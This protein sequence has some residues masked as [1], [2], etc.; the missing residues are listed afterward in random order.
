MSRKLN[1][2]FHVNS[3]FWV[4]TLILGFTLFLLG[5]T[6][7]KPQKAEKGQIYTKPSG[8][9]EKQKDNRPPK[10]WYWWNNV[11]EFKV[12]ETWGTVAIKRFQRLTENNAILPAD[13][14]TML[15][16]ARSPL[17]LDTPW[18]D[19][20]TGPVENYI[21]AKADKFSLFTVFKL[22]DPAGNPKEG[23]V[24]QDFNGQA[25][26]Y[27]LNEEIQYKIA[28]FDADGVVGT[29]TTR[30]TDK[31]IRQFLH[32]SGTSEVA[33][34]NLLFK[35][36]KDPKR[37]YFASNVDASTAG[38]Y[39][40][41]L[42]GN[43]QWGKTSSYSQVLK[44]RIHWSNDGNILWC[45][46]AS[47]GYG[48]LHKIDITSGDVLFSITDLGSP[49][50]YLPTTPGIDGWIGEGPDDYI[51]KEYYSHPLITNAKNIVKFDKTSGVSSMWK[52]NAEDPDD[53]CFP[54]HFYNPY[55]QPDVVKNVEGTYEIILAGI[56][57]TKTGHLDLRSGVTIAS[58]YEVFGGGCEGTHAPRFAFEDNKHVW[59]HRAVDTYIGYDLGVGN[60]IVA[61]QLAYHLLSDGPGFALAGDYIVFKGSNDGINYDSLVTQYWTG[62]GQERAGTTN[63]AN[64]T[65]YR[66][67]RLDSHTIGDDP[68]HPG[69]RAS[70]ITFGPSVSG[71]GAAFY[72]MQTSETTY[73]NLKGRFTK[74]GSSNVG[75]T[76]TVMD[77]C[78]GYSSRRTAYGVV[79]ATSGNTE[80]FVASWGKD[81]GSAAWG[82]YYNV[83]G[84]PQSISPTQDKGYII[85]GATGNPDSGWDTPTSF[86]MKVDANGN[87]EWVK[88]YKPDG[89]GT[90]FYD[91]IQTEDQG[92]MAIGGVRYS[93][94]ES[95]IYLVKTN[96]HGE[97]CSPGVPCE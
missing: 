38:I 17:Q 73:Q 79:G 33:G 76:G 45:F 13:S 91:A 8:I 49:N 78:Q 4:F 23:I 42:F 97:S 10:G 64:S 83:G 67:Y 18:L 51:I 61:T 96:R 11:G 39:V 36:K 57:P 58:G 85:S 54:G 86:L 77:V 90:V 72:T 95:A 53:D 71:P 74:K 1:P 56:D 88:N 26:I 40:T 55:V 89:A 50:W 12:P 37:I 7:D 63:F 65:A 19:A 15:T 6:W 3:H 41:D 34:K 25:K 20:K 81:G 21:I 93:A 14:K 35:E 62:G 94:S 47:Y 80:T 46:G 29:N 60:E 68:S 84:Y 22:C 16:W 66:Y 28:C 69:V 32:N 31:W 48:E 30:L 59:I 87:Q 75:N 5:A 70:Y 27:G 24:E 92:F 44:N 9:Y 43:L 82:K 52:L 2:H